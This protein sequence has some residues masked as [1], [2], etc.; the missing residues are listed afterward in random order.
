MELRE[1][2]GDIRRP[3]PRGSNAR[4]GFFGD[5]RDFLQGRGSKNV[6]FREK[7][8]QHSELAAYYCKTGRNVE[9]T[10]GFIIDYLTIFTPN[11][12]G[13]AEQSRR[14]VCANKDG[15]GSLYVDQRCYWQL[16][17]QER[18][19]HAGLCRAFLA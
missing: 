9:N 7:N 11:L 19:S 12:M 14:N 2:I 15:A 10:I 6:N 4:L 3:G 8:R 17:A 1:I 5:P 13:L 16:T 18:V